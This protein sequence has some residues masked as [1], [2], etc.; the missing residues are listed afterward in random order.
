MKYVQ[1]QIRKDGII[2]TSPVVAINRLRDPP[3]RLK[4]AT[5]LEKPPPTF[6]EESS[7]LFIEAWWDNA[8]FMRQWT[9]SSLTMACHLVD[10]KPVHKPVWAYCHVDPWEHTSVKFETKCRHS[11]SRIMVWKCH[12]QN[13]VTVVTLSSPAAPY[14]VIMIIAGASCDD[15]VSIMVTVGCQWT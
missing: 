5:T 7:G 4:V 12:L 9:A 14:V 10:P 6:A 1:S 3:T 2:Q 11:Y 13:V 15:K 8:A